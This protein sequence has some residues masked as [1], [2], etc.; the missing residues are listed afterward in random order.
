[1]A[2]V[3]TIPLLHIILKIGIILLVVPVALIAEARIKGSATALYAA[4]IIMYAIVV[5]N[6][7]SILLP[8]IIISFAG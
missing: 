2:G 6:N 8:H 3:V 5:L 4:L 1:M 7:T